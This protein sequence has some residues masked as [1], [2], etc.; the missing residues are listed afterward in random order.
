MALHP[1]NV[2]M[3]GS[4]IYKPDGIYFYS[5]KLYCSP[6]ESEKKKEIDCEELY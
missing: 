5:L 2:S 3:S 4:I 6:N 1:K